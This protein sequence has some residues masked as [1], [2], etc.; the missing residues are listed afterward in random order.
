MLV[1]LAAVGLLPAIVVLTYVSFWFGLL[2][3]RIIR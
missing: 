3:H 2:V 1:A